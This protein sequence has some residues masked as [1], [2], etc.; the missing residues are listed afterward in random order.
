MKKMSD[1][2]VIKAVVCA[3]NN[4]KGEC[5]KCP[6]YYKGECCRGQIKND[7]LELIDRQK[8][9]IETMGYQSYKYYFELMK[10]K[11]KKKAITLKLK[12]LLKKMRGEW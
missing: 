4:D 10:M 2:E 8:L 12:K 7:V 5:E 9:E 3:I 6:Y 1:R 11:K